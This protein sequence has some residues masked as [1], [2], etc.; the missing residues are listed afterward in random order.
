[1]TVNKLN[2]CN[3]LRF[4]SESILMFFLFIKRVQTLS[5]CELEND[6]VDIK[7]GDVYVKRR[8]TILANENESNGPY[9]KP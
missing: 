3:K 1:M 7:F 2:K 9:F 5:Y 4:H 8:M 6:R